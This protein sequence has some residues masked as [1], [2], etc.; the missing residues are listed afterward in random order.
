MPLLSMPSSIGTWRVERP[1]SWRKQALPSFYTFSTPFLT[2]GDKRRECFEQLEKY[3][4]NIQNDNIK[5]KTPWAFIFLARWGCVQR[6]DRREL[7]NPVIQWSLMSLKERTV[8]H[9]F[10]IY[11][12]ISS[13]QNRRK[14]SSKS[15]HI[16]VTQFFLM[17][18]S[19]MLT[20]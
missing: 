15:L 8:L 7:M 10:L 19:S 13:L 16:L 4:L 18:T 1:S 17:L 12:I 11:L 9:F 5:G 20:I 14:T 2:G 3:S 6:Q